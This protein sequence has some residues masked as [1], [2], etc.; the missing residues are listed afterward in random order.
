MLS[1]SLMFHWTIEFTKLE[2]K[3]KKTICRINICDVATV[4]VVVC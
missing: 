2:E 4:I 1:N 3:R